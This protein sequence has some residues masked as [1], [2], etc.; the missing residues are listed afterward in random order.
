M[1]IVYICALYKQEEN[2]NIGEDHFFFFL[3]IGGGALPNLL[4]LN[5]FDEDLAHP[6]LYLY[7]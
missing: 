6:L 5:Q 4:Q 7:N 1:I 3:N 2:L